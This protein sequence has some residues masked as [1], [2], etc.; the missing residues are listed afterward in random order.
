MNS[1]ANMYYVAHDI[2]AVSPLLSEWVTECQAYTYTVS[3][4]T[5]SDV[6][7]YV[8]IDAHVVMQVRSLHHS[9][10]RVPITWPVARFWNSQTDK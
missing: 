9:S 6:V 4:Y 1:V 8:R 10:S 7:M 2:L 5:R 3:K